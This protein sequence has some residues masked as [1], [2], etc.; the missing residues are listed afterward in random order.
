MSQQ[1]NSRF[2]GKI[3][4]FVGCAGLVWSLSMFVLHLLMLESPK[5]A[6]KQ[7]YIMLLGGMAFLIEVSDIEKER[8]ANLSKVSWISAVALLILDRY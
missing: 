5:E 7:F 3:L 2:W 1:S 6:V 8:R 4:V